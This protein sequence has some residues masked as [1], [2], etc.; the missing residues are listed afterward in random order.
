MFYW[1]DETGRKK[2]KGGGEERLVMEHKFNP[3]YYMGHAI[4]KSFCVRAYVAIFGFI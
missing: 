1:E 4:Q 3:S 2:K